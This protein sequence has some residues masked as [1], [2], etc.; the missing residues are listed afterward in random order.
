[1]LVIYFV[2]SKAYQKYYCVFHGLAIYILNVT[3]TLKLIVTRL[4]RCI[5]V[6]I[7]GYGQFV[8]KLEN[9]HD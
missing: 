7:S 6:S 3:V 8:Y 2:L 4:Q 1:M 9:R 5:S